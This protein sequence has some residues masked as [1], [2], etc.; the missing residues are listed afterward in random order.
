MLVAAKRGHPVGF[1]RVQGVRQL[2]E[3]ADVAAAPRECDGKVA[4]RLRI[5]MCD[6]HGHARIC[7]VPSFL[8]VTQAPSPRFLGMS[9]VER[10]RRV[11]R[12]HGAAD[13]AA[14]PTG[15]PT[16][17]IP[18]EAAITAALFPQLGTLSPSGVSRI[19][20]HPEHPPLLWRGDGV[21]DVSADR[22]VLTAAAVLDVSTPAARRAAAWQLLKASGKPQ[23]GWLSRHVHRKVSRLFSYVFMELGL[24][25]NVAT[26][27]TFCVG[28]LAAYMMAQTSHRTMIAG[29]FLFWF[30]SI[31]DGIDGE[32]ARLTLSE[33]T[34]GEQLDTGV[35]QLTH[36]SGLIGVL[37]GWWR[38][39]IGPGGV[40]LA[41]AVVLGTPAVLLWAMALIRQARQ[42]DQFFV[43]TKPIEHAIVKAADDTAAL[44][45]RA[46]AAVFILFRREA[47][48]LLFFLLSLVTAQRAAIPAAIAVGLA[49]VVVTLVGYGAT[50][51]RA[52]REIVGPR[53]AGTTTA[54]AARGSSGPA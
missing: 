21:A 51:D 1:A 33:S 24:S 7:I 50:L 44:P 49:V 20:W 52:L 41:V 36:L 15:L 18:A 28:L 23:D 32:I 31:A 5:A 34:F 3:L 46:A 47:F 11:A 42:T 19:V 53:P 45:L 30:A 12:R 4:L 2:D 25:A 13:A 43:P 14:T 16:L 38:Q 39:G 26:T 17:T 40:A 27:L 8:I 29:G 22:L 9:T 37:V 10:N 54:P 6:T 48:S 35:D